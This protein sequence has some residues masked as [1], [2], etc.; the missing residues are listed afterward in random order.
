MTW[1]IKRSDTTASSKANGVRVDRKK[2]GMITMKKQ[3]IPKFETEEQEAEYWDTNSPLDVAPEPKAERVTVEGAKDRPL[4]IRLDSESRSKFD[5]LA[6]QQGLGPSCFGR[7]IIASVIEGRV[8]LPK[9]ITPNELK[10]LLEKNLPQSIKDQSESLLRA[11]SIGDPNNPSAL[12]LDKSQIDQ[13]GELGLQAISTLLAYYG[14]LII[15]PEHNKYE[16]IKALVESG[17]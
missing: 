7:L 1:R 2:E 10:G 9:R 16:E 12:F 8:N 5:K 13:W 17:T 14:L 6:A 4:T 11:A 3:L 15:T